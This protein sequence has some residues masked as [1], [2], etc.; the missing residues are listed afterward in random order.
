MSVLLQLTL[1][2]LAGVLVIAAM[3][4]FALAS[5]YVLAL[6]LELGDENEKEG[7]ERL[8]ERSTR[9]EKL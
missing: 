3:L 8:F 9:N 5:L 7:V 1:G 4:A 2:T 6:V